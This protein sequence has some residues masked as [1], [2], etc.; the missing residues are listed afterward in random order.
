MAFIGVCTLFSF[1]LTSTD[2]IINRF[3]I[4]RL[5]CKYLIGWDI[6]SGLEFITGVITLRL[7]V[8]NLMMIFNEIGMKVVSLNN[9]C[10]S[11]YLHL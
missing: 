1:V 2:F 5:H 10:G 8:R 4:S 6:G 11:S 3:V 7:D 9:Y